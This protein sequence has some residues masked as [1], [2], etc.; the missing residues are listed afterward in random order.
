MIL[1][2]I[3]FLT[4]DIFICSVNKSDGYSILGNITFLKIIILLKSIQDIRSCRLNIIKTKNRWCI[5]LWE[6]IYSVDFI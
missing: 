4:N 6:N 3:L 2:M 5:K 1:D